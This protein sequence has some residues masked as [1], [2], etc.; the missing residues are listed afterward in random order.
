VT[1]PETLYFGVLGGIAIV[2]GIAL[3][4]IARPVLRLMSGVR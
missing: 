4:L 2:L 3:A 1:V